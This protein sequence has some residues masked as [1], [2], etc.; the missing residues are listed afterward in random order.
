MHCPRQLYHIQHCAKVMEMNFDEFLGF[1]EKFHLKRYFKEISL[2][3]QDT[4]CF[5][6]HDFSNNNKP[7]Y[8]CL[9]SD[10]A[11]EWQRG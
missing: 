6:P 5:D 2:H 9:L 1:S 3:F 8:S 4:Y 11:F 7:F 10:L